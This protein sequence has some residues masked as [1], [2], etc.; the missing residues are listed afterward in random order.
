MLPFW[1][2]EIIES[3]SLVTWNKVLDIWL[4][5]G[6]A[7]KIFLDRWLEVYATWLEIDSYNI[8]TELKEKIKE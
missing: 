3:L 4:W 7:S 1:T 6:D 5:D 8:S 2:K